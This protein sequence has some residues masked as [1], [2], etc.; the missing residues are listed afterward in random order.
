MELCSFE[1]MVDPRLPYRRF[2]FWSGSTKSR[3]LS[4]QKR[5]A[6]RGDNVL[7]GEENRGPLACSKDN[8]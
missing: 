4:E 7:L 8:I 5:V 2:L 3:T 6:T 1:G